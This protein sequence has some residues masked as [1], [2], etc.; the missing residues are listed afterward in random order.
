MR[1]R[2]TTLI[3]LT[4]LLAHPLGGLCAGIANQPAKKKPHAAKSAT[5]K[6]T[7]EKVAVET[8]KTITWP[9]RMLKLIATDMGRA[10]ILYLPAVDTD[11]NR[12]ITAGAMPIFLIKDPVTSGIQQIH[13]PSLTYN[14]IFGVTPTWRYYYYPDAYSQIFTRAAYS[15]FTNR[16]LTLEYKNSRFS[17]KH[18]S[19]DTRFQYF[20]EGSN[21]FFGLG[22]DSKE[23]DQTNYTLSTLRY[24]LTLGLPIQGPLRLDLTYRLNSDKI[25]DGP[26]KTLPDMENLFSPLTPSTRKVLMRYKMGLTY[27]SR[28][29][30]TAPQKGILAN[31]FAETSSQSLGSDANF[32]DFGAEFRM[33]YPHPSK[34]GWTSVGRILLEQQEGKNIPFYAQ[35][36]IGG[37]ETLRGYGDGRFMDK[38]R[39]VFGFEER[40]NV[41]QARI[42]DVLSQFELDP[43][44]ELGTVFPSPNRME[45]KHIRPVGGLAVRAVV[46]P[47]VVGSFD[48]GFGQEGPALFVDINYSF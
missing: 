18:L 15:Q 34:P 31:V 21:R 10:V 16:D 20:R 42:M 47:Q 3:F 25:Q 45:A 30:P 12:G 14:H 32:Q 19:V 39:L 46:R 48:A 4:L 40:I 1:M 22:P 36:A 41:A 13:A 43:F 9:L 2:R 17:Q 28:D 8:A 37:K 24:R 27:D 6:T 29:N 38:G 23:K 26:I 5:P 7:V 35:P 33:L 11:P 44:F